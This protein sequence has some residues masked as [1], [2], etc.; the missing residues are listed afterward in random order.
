MPSQEIAPNQNLPILEPTNALDELIIALN[1]SVS[2]LMSTMIGT[3]LKKVLESYF[4]DDKEGKIEDA[5]QVL[6]TQRQERLSELYKIGEIM[7]S[8]D[9][10]TLTA[11][12][13]PCLKYQLQNIPDYIKPRELVSTSKIES[14]NIIKNLRDF[15]FWYQLFN[16]KF[17]SNIAIDEAK[18]G[19]F[20]QEIVIEKAIET[21]LKDQF[22]NEDLKDTGLIT[23]LA[24]YLYDRLIDPTL[25]EATCI[26]NY[27]EDYWIWAILGTHN[28]EIALALD[29]QLFYNLGNDGEV[30]ETVYTQKPSESSVKSSIPTALKLVREN[31]A[32]NI[33][34]Y[35][36]S[37]IKIDGLFD[38]ID[39]I[40][41]LADV[42]TE[43]GTL[44][45][46]IILYDKLLKD[47]RTQ[48]LAIYLNNIFGKLQAA[49][50]V[51]EN[52][53]GAVKS[54]ITGYSDITIKIK[55]K[56]DRIYEIQLQTETT[57]NNKA[58]ETVENDLRKK[59]LGEIYAE[60]EEFIRSFEKDPYDDKNLIQD[61]V[62]L[63]NDDFENFNQ[64]ALEKIK[65]YLG[66]T[67]F[68][69]LDKSGL[70]SLIT[71]IYDL[72]TNYGQSIARSRIIYKVASFL[73]TKDDFN[74]LI[75]LLGDEYKSVFRDKITEKDQGYFDRI[76]PEFEVNSIPKVRMFVF[77]INEKGE[78]KIALQE[79]NGTHGRGNLS[80]FGGSSVLLEYT[81]TERI[82]LFRKQE[83]KDYFNLNQILFDTVL[84][85]ELTQ[86]I[87]TDTGG[88]NFTTFALNSLDGTPLSYAITNPTRPAE[89]PS[90]NYPVMVIVNV[91]KFADISLDSAG[92]E[93]CKSNPVL[94][95]PK[96]FFGSLIRC[97]Y[98]TDAENHSFNANLGQL[99]TTV[100]L[101]LYQLYNQLTANELNLEFKNL[102]VT[103]R[104][105]KREKV[106]ETCRTVTYFK[107]DQGQIQ[108]LVL[109]NGA[110]P[111]EKK[112]NYLPPT[113]E[114]WNKL[115]LKGK[116]NL[117][118][119]AML[120][121]LNNPENY[122]KFI[123]LNGGK[124]STQK[125]NLA[126][127]FSPKP[128]DSLEFP[129][130]KKEYDSVN[131]SSLKEF[132]EETGLYETQNNL[133]Q[134]YNINKQEAKIDEVLK[135]NLTNIALIIKKIEEFYQSY[136][137]DKLQI[138][139]G[140]NK[141]GNPKKI[142]YF[143]LD[144]TK[145]LGADLARLFANYIIVNTTM[146]P[147]GKP[148]DNHNTF[149]IVALGEWLYSL[150]YKHPTDMSGNIMVV[151]HS[152]L[153]DRLLNAF[154]LT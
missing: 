8:F 121:Y 154:G 80:T 53:S 90:L 105:E 56:K 18:T 89:R 69:E 60:N 31:D 65:E 49:E 66:E 119:S 153:D 87:S 138:R 81:D 114:E 28:N 83:L 110:I 117:V 39:H 38:R 143:N 6:G 101:A 85:R 34:D 17:D 109:K 126:A 135:A 63:E 32:G 116:L 123:K 55:D 41:I 5:S 92:T 97:S 51:I 145:V 130:G 133:Q 35:F 10:A 1:S 48:I 27:L 84:A 78:I 104:A 3:S 30:L 91:E 68:E 25:D 2:K 43:G 54:T 103:T 22:T 107:D 47:T 152:Q 4:G 12:N 140:I 118:D 131:L 88:F 44:A 124:I 59:Y 16:N 75:S 137:K 125:K 70:Q 86:V 106:M 132:M 93:H 77:L 76:E 52:Q 9:P 72:K 40:A 64:S 26:Q 73:T 36:R 50:Y 122:K 112:Y 61:L 134:A 149:K 139:E 79:K 108:F 146:N 33:H 129:G 57:L 23:E 74:K 98:F 58:Q 71:I 11:N 45:E 62:I 128:E 102:P 20:I 147:M 141:D 142:Y 29:Q 151:D 94:I 13:Y 24:K 100:V 96:E 7:S 136:P 127:T 99:P 120:D 19:F 67:A 113:F 82:S 14:L 42:K 115:Q 148:D 46:Q 37:T 150:Q 15:N 21:W 95:D 111:D 144:L